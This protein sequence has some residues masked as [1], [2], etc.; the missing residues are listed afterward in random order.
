[1]ANPENEKNL[2]IDMELHRRIK[3]MASL[4]GVSLI[5]LANDMLTK[6]ICDAEALYEIKRVQHMPGDQ[7]QK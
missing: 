2:R 5:E 7:D 3:V 4:K 6:A 1:M